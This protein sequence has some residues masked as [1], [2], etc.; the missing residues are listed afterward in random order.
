MHNT[1]SEQGNKGKTTESIVENYAQM[2]TCVF[3]LLI[4][5]IF[6]F[7]APQGYVEIG[8]HKFHFFKTVGLVCFGLLLPAYGYRIRTKIKN[9]NG[10][11]MSVTD[12]ALL[13]YGGAVLLSFLCSD[14]KK[15]ALWGT[16]GW[17]M[18]TLTQ[19]MFVACYFAVSRFVRRV[20]VWYGIFISVSSVVFLHGILNRFSI[21]PVQLE[22]ANPG[23]ISTLGNINWFCSYWMLVFPIGLVF[24]WSGIGKTVLQKAALICFALLGFMTGIVQGSSSGFLAL[25]VMAFVLFL[26]SFEEEEKLLKWLELFLL[27]AVSTLLTSV[28]KGWFP[29][30][31]NYQNTIEEILTEY[32]TGLL[33][34]TAAVIC[35]AIMHYLLKI[36]KFN[37]RKFL[38]FRNSVVVLFLLVFAIVFILVISYCVHPENAGDSTIA[39]HFVIDEDWG[40]GRGTTWMAGIQAFVSMPIE[41]KVIGVGPDCFYLFVYSKWELAV[42]LYQVFGDARLTNA[43]NEWLTILINTGVCGLLSYAAVFVTSIFRQIKAGK[44]QALLLVS[45]VCMITYTIHNMVSFQQ[46]ICTPIAFILLG[47]GENLIRKNN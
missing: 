25:A 38:P 30:N 45:A 46:V 7:Y 1:Y 28:L 9:G 36:K 20:K 8:S 26:L 37:I 33:L 43:H 15:E 10:I 18:G 21:Y 34:L 4:I 42:K 11:R 31:F 19:L 3:L 12:K 13:L 24:Y 41:K 27:F 44:K 40:N 35:Y 2:V 23:F 39:E 22:G 14:W 16:E 47:M 32:A 29:E 5:V 17:Y 6:P